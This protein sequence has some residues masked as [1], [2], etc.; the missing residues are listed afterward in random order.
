M[1]HVT[2]LERILGSER[3]SQASCDTAKVGPK[4][5]DLAVD[6]KRF[7]D[8]V[9]CDESAR[10]QME[11]LATVLVLTI[12]ALEVSG[13]LPLN[14]TQ[15]ITALR[16]SN[17]SNGYAIVDRVKGGCLGRLAVQLK[18]GGTKHWG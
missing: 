12:L 2:P 10:F 9:V 8:I 15:S 11:H 7:C 17:P 18:H 3:M 4:A 13:N 1:L 16:S 14:Y 6:E 5:V